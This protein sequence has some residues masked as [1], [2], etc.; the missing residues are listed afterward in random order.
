MLTKSG[1]QPVLDVTVKNIKLNAEIK[2]E[3][4]KPASLN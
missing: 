1:D 4:F 3:E 2:E